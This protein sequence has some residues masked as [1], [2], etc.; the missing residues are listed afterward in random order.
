MDNRKNIT[1]KK[2]LLI[3][4]SAEK[5]ALININRELIPA[6]DD[7][8]HY[9]LGLAYLYSA[10]EKA[11][12][13]VQL[14]FL[15]KHDDNDCYN[16]IKDALGKFLPE[17]VGFQMLTF[18][19][20]STYRMIECIH[21]KYPH[22]HQ[23]IGGIHATAMYQQ[24]IK[25]Y[26][27][28]IAVMSEGEI[29]FPDLLN[30]LAEP[31]PN[32]NSVDGIAFSENGAVKETKPKKLIENLDDIP[33]PKHE[34]FFKEKRKIGSIITT[35]GCP[36]NCSF[37]C[38]N[39]VSR[40][41]VRMR[42]VDNIIKEIEWMVDKFPQMDTIWIQDDTFFVDNQRVIDFCDEI[43]KRGIKI[44]FACNGRMKPISEK[45]VKKLEQ[46]NFKRIFLGLESGDNRILKKCHKGITQEDAINAYKLFAKTK[47][48]I[49][50]HLIV[51]LSGE[52][53]DTIMETANFMK[54]LQ[55]IKY[56]PNYYPYLLIV[57]PGTEIYEIAK[58]AGSIGDDYWL[59]DKPAPFFTT[60]NSYEQL[61]HFQEIL[62][63]NVSLTRA[64]F[65]WTGF[66]AQFSIIPCHLKY[67]FNNRKNA[68][69]F[70]IGAAKFILPAGIYGYLK[71]IYHRFKN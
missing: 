60:E 38:L 11:G 45:M 33:F 4:T 70:F 47:I 19:R 64:L 62:L 67:I 31:K 10:L 8:V 2:I 28:V 6:T 24:I 46:A 40:N 16:K 57:F 23:I 18:N 14:L 49:Y 71:K 12:H 37:C 42:T 25:K 34:L 1:P 41:R 13:E 27:Y 69:Y 3:S 53:I 56:V 58:A 44:N 65:T 63:Y 7:G 43:I 29:V 35:R 59:S 30:E 17:I 50:S 32:L 55:K 21:E 66:K 54:K 9:P 5:N 15:T 68:K 26:P 39:F 48:N 52:N 36:F 20:V 51:G 61:I 22:I